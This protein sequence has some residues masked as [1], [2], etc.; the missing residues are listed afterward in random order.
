M[1]DLAEAE[2]DVRRPDRAGVV[3]RLGD[4]VRGHVDANH[5]ATAAHLTHGQ[6]AIEATPRA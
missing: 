2:L 3:A 4:H 1:L 5:T 6:E